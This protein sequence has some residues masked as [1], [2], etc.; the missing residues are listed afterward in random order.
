[1][2]LG[3]ASIGKLITLRARFAASDASGITGSVHIVTLQALT[4][5]LHGFT[6]IAQYYDTDER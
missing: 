6:S 1:M 2:R 4:A 3:V 5:E